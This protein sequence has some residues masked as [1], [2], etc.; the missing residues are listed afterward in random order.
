MNQP[1][2]GGKPVVEFK[3]DRHVDHHAEE[4]D[5]TG[6][7]RHLAELPADQPAD[8]AFLCAGE[9]G[10]GEILS[11][12]VHQTG[13]VRGRVAAAVVVLAAVGN[14]DFQFLVRAARS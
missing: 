7:D 14:D 3:T 6:D 10:F 9:S 13:A 5:D 8:R 4:R 11:Q 12:K 2:H 1:E